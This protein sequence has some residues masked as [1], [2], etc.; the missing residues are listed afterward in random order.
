MA[1]LEQITRSA[2]LGEEFLTWLWHLS[3][4]AH[5]PFKV[6]KVGSCQIAMGQ[7]MILGNGSADAQTVVLRGEMPSAS[8][9]ARQA[10]AAGKRLRRAKFYLTIENVQ[11]GCTIVGTTLTISGLRV[12]S[13]AGADFDS[14]CLARLDAVERF[15]RAIQWL[16]EQFLE[17]RLNGK[18]WDAELRAVGKWAAGK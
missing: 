14:H 18:R 3:E 9:E 2:F 13:A 10:L 5:D 11:W 16:F 4:T 15:D 6:P 17:R 12:P 8:P 7:D 1:L